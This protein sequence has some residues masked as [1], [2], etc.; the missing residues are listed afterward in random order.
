MRRVAENITGGEAARGGGEVM[1]PQCRAMGHRARLDPLLHMD[2]RPCLIGAMR[3]QTILAPVVDLV[4]PPRCPLCGDAVV[5]GDM[6]HPA[7][8]GDC[9]DRLEMP[10]VGGCALCQRGLRDGGDVC[11]TCRANPPLHDGIAAATLY[12][13]ASRDLVLALKYGGR[14]ALA[15]L[16]ARLMA[17]RLGDVDADWLVVPV[18]LHRWRLWR[19]GFNQS[20]LLARHIARHKGAR[21]L[22]DGLLRKRH[23]PSLRGMDH[24]ARAQ[25]MRGA[26]AVK[27]GAEAR[28]S[29]ARVLLVDDVLTSGATTNACIAA[30][31]KSGA[32][33]V[34]IACFARV[35]GT[36]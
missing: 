20:A 10:G 31:R 11:G 29:E 33:R 19:R 1:A 27:P 12:N 13:D 32:A 5:G 16:L 8:C 3:L 14:I 2:T 9:W 15:P 34:K 28:L 26:I 24:D 30:L 17:A 23:T 25:V 35:A 21:L 22:V 7:L 4:F 6:G 36:E 18:P